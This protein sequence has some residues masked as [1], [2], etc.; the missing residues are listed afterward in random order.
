[1]VLMV[2]LMVVVLDGIV[3][4]PCMVV[5]V[6]NLLYIH[7]SIIGNYYYVGY[8]HDG[9]VLLLIMVLVASRN[10]L[11]RMAI[12]HLAERSVIV[13]NMMVADLVMVAVV[14]IAVAVELNLGMVVNLVFVDQIQMYLLIDTFQVNYVENIMNLGNYF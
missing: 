13:V 7:H 4:N 8:D 9:M 3:L 1:M 6:P 14:V 2:L 10:S 11:G 5:A 12:K